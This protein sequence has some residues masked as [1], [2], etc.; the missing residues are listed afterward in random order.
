MS[1]S[2]K[3]DRLDEQGGRR[4]NGAIA[5]S[6]AA[7]IKIESLRLEPQGR[8]QPS[9]TENGL[10]APATTLAVA[11]KKKEKKNRGVVA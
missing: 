6:T 7:H 9:V 8:R 10:Q 2:E 11:E 1:T 5:V 3:D 4:S